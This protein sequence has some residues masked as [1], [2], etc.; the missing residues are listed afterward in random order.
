MFIFS[1][2]G[3]LTIN[4]RCREGPC[5]DGPPP[6]QLL[7]SVSG[8]QQ[9]GRSIKQQEKQQ[10]QQQ[11]QKGQPSKDKQK[12]QQDGMLEAGTKSMNN[13]EP[14]TSSTFAARQLELVYGT[15]IPQKLKVSPCG[16][17]GCVLHGAPLCISDK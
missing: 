8:Q 11:R 1:A 4:P 15:F 6:N 10:Q 17:V 16:K 5:W 13:Q 2:D 9:Q 7:Q 3:L 14:L 12:Q